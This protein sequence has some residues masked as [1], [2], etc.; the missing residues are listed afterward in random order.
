ME[1]IQVIQFICNIIMLIGIF[2]NSYLL[3]KKDKKIDELE[4]KIKKLEERG[5]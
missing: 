5:K 3:T 2:A 4:K 1:T